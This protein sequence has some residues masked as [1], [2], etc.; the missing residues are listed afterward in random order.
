MGPLGPTRGPMGEGAG[1]TPS[2]GGGKGAWGPMGPP[3]ATP[4]VRRFVVRASSA[5]YLRVFFVESASHWPESAQL[6]HTLP[7][8][9]MRP[10]FQ[11]GHFWW[12]LVVAHLPL[13]ELMPDFM[14]VQPHV[15]KVR[16]LVDPKIAQLEAFFFGEE[17]HRI[18]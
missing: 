9:G 10:V 7:K 16:H 1:G 18:I 2:G 6:V 14:L 11:F 12:W 17:P 8:L 13:T 3:C 5:P 15:V 4:T